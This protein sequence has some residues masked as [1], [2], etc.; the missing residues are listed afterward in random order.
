[1]TNETDHSI[2]STPAAALEESPSTEQIILSKL[3]KQQS[4]GLGVV[5]ATVMTLVN[6]YGVEFLRNYGSIPMLCLL[7]PAAITGFMIKVIARPY[8]MTARIV[9][10]LSLVLMT[11][12][13]FN[14]SPPSIPSIFVPLLS[15]FICLAASRRFLDPNQ[16]A[17]LYK[18]RLGKLK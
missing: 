16:E 13:H 3:K 7:M 11:A 14:W 9:P 18:V 8:T 15:G 2:Y 17:V 6:F 12:A 5:V 1:M 4:I 10:T